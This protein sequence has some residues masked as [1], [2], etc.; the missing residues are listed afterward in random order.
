MPVVD[1][2]LVWTLM[3]G[4]P[5]LMASHPVA[6]PPLPIEPERPEKVQEQ[7]INLEEFSMEID[8]RDVQCGAAE[9]GTGRRAPFAYNP[10]SSDSSQ[11][12]TFQATTC[13]LRF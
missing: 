3:T 13:R 5:L 9:F 11:E 1:G 8:G 2:V 4:L 6:P 12:V 10:D 7:S